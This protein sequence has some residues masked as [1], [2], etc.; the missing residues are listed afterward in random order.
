MKVSIGRDFKVNVGNYEN[1]GA[2][3]HV[4]V[5]PHDLGYSPTSWADHVAEVGAV[6][7]ALEMSTLARGFLV[8]LAQA[9]LADIEPYIEDPE[10]SFAPLWL[11]HHEPAD[12]PAPKK[13]G[14]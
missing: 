12:E 1:M 2:S 7:A 11:D 3:V 13:R 5:E 6:E 4:S 9:E 14:S 8:G 10:R